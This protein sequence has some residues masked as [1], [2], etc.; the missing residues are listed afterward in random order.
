MPLDLPEGASCF[1][2]SNILYYALVPT[3]SVSEHCLR[4]VDRV[5]ARNVTIAVS[6]P[7]LSD[8]IH[9]VM[10]SEAAQKTGRDRVGMIGYLGK[11]PEVIKSLVE[12]P[13]AMDRLSALPM[14]ILA[15]DETILR[16]SSQLAVQF[17]L[18]TN[19]A[20]IVALMR[21]HQLAHLVTNDDDFDSVSDV[22][23][24]KPR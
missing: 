20:M 11:H 8:T 10:T 12:Y 9:K 7:V 5:M 17:G 6:I 21:R 19:D 16:E 22:R 24:W 23:V 15:V 13:K 3:A 4:F 18:M 2:D 1:V 14:Q